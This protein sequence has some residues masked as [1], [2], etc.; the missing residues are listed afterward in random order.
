MK[1]I[2]GGIAVAA[3]IAV[4]AA[5]ILDTGVQRDAETAFRT[6]SVRL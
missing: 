5:F 6:E 1:S 2:I 3:L 4:G